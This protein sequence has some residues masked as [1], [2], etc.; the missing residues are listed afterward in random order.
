MRSIG[1]AELLVSLGVSLV[2]IM[3]IVQVVQVIKKRRREM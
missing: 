2:L 3:F 1:R